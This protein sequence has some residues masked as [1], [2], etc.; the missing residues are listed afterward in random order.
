MLKQKRI[1]LWILVIEVDT[2]VQ[3]RNSTLKYG[4]AEAP[5]ASCERSPTPRIRLDCSNR[6]LE[7][8]G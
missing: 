2:G 4:V 7:A 3:P 5:L 6:R 8:M 1:S